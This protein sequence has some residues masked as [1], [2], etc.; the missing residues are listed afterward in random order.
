VGVL[1]DFH[2][3][4]EHVFLLSGKLEIRR[5]PVGVVVYLNYATARIVDEDAT[6]SSGIVSLVGEIEEWEASIH[7]RTEPVL[8]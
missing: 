4:P 8:E 7:R 6:G 5:E 1:P 2:V 3:I